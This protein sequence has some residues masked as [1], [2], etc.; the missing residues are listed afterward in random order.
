MTAQ[1]LVDAQCAWLDTSQVPRASK[2]ALN[3]V[4]V[5]AL[6]HLKYQPGLDLGSAMASLAGKLLKLWYTFEPPVVTCSEEEVH[7]LIENY[8]QMLYR[9][10]DEEWSGS[11]ANLTHQR[12]SLEDS[13]YFLLLDR[14]GEK[15]GG[16]GRGQGRK[17][18]LQ[19]PV[20]LSFKA[21]RAAADRLKAR[22]ESEGRSY[23]DLLREMVEEI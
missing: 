4:I 14:R 15:R 5:L 19:D 3:Q 23:A 17:P 21:E 16:P 7:G 1:E 11:L 13:I 8:V 2:T 18:E 9:H 6:D 22:A 12:E 10:F 20:V